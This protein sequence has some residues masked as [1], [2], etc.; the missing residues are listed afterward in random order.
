MT[1]PL[2]DLVAQYRT[3]QPDIDAA[4]R[5]V[6][7]GGH[8]I[9][10]P[11][12]RALERE[13]ASYLG[14]EN[15]VGVASGTDALILAL[16]ALGIGP[17]DEVIVPDYTFLATASAVLHAGATPVL[18]DVDPETFNI[19]VQAAAAQITT[20][21]CAL[22][23]VHLFGLP[24]DMTAVM[25]LAA[26]HGLAVI[27]D[28]AQALGASY[29]GRRTGAI[30]RIG[31][32]SF[33]PSKNL[34]GYGDGGMVV[35]DDAALAERVRILRTH[36]WREKY[37]PEVLGYNSR[38]DEMQAAVLRVKLPHLDAWNAE[39]GRRARHYAAAFAGT[40]VRTP[41]ERPESTHVH[42]LYVVR[43]PQRATMERTLKERGIATAIYYPRPLHMTQLFR[44]S[45][46]GR[47]FPIS[48]ALSEELLAIPL[49]PEMSDEQQ[50]AVVAAVRTAA[51]AVT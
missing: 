42:H 9:L 36:G 24:A 4:I 44:E 23:P 34:G 11:H 32:L 49:Y 6:L 40:P 5:S 28:N 35:T 25:D 39:R 2:A 50:D 16:R 15:G 43:V 10:G 14:L 26:A 45:V 31:C 29:R 20:R 46:R 12:T 21:T 13:V 22:I 18:V 37:D 17:G 30:G 47:R 38:L 48:G 33:F 41:V 51:L 19:D 1:I 27:E 3:I 8:F 7:E